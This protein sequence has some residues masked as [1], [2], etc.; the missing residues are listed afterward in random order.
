[1]PTQLSGHKWFVKV[2]KIFLESTDSVEASSFP[3]VVVGI[4]A[5]LVMLSL[6]AFAIYCTFCKKVRALNIDLQTSPEPVPEERV[7]FRDEE[8]TPRLTNAHHGIPSVGY[9]GEQEVEPENVHF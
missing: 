8:G 9:N 1:M 6:L 3:C 4:V 7:L 5:V 2:T